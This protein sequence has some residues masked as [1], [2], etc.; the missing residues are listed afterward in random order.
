MREKHTPQSG[1]VRP[2]GTG[3]GAHSW[4]TFSRRS[5]IV[6]A[7]GRPCNRADSAAFW[8]WIRPL[9]FAA[10]KMAFE[11]VYVMHTQLA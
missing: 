11:S 4:Y 6:C 2:S 8:M 9:A 10:M 3:V 1:M 7:E 5:S